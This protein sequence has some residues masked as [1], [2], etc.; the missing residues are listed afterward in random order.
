MPSIS[1]DGAWL[2]MTQSS[3]DEDLLLLKLDGSMAP[4]AHERSRLRS[5]PRFSPDGKRVAFFSYRSGRPQIWEIHTDGSGLRH[6]PLDGHDLYYPVYSPDGARLVAA[7]DKGSTW[8]VD[9]TRSDSAWVLAHE[10][11]SERASRGGPKSWSRDGSRIAGD[12]VDQ[13]FR[14]IG[15][16]VESAE[17]GERRRLTDSGELPVW[18]SDS[19]RLLYL[20]A[21]AI[22]LLDTT[23]GRSSVVLP[24][25]RAPRQVGYFDV[26]M[27][28]AFIVVTESRARA[29]S[30]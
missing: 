21:G 23:T 10:A 6:L 18:L 27:D 1:P 13:G 12:L 25:A 19:R 22:R 16:F 29:T 4:P 8:R 9:L 26:S 14:R 20:D 28:D 30:G 2:A 15:V 11:S 3:P 5:W 7:D 24:A 17:T